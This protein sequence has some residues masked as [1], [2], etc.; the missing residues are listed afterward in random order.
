MQTRP[1]A[2]QSSSRVSS[3]QADAHEQLK[4]VVRQHL[5]TPWQAPLARHTVEAFDA[6]RELLVWSESRPIVLDSGCGTGR[7]TLELGRMY[8]DC[9]VI[10]VDR[11]A[12]RL[13]SGTGRTRWPY[14]EGNC[15]WLR[16]ELTSF[17]RL[18]LDEGWGLHR[19]YLLYPN[20]WP[21]CSQLRK[22][23][24]GHPV[25]PVILRLGGVIELR[26]NWS[27][28]A[29]EFAQAVELGTGRVVNVESFEVVEPLSP[30][31][32][33]YAASD[34]LLYRVNWDSG[35]SPQNRD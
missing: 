31:E 4:H 5:D 30:F 27:I 34:H 19:H 20:P 7:S 35:V 22:R 16:A 10:G 12:H 11:S 32:R 9:V 29:Q 13:R 15:I 18:L 3:N 6:L 24:H 1:Q 17:W 28:Y 14:R 23:W 2:S 33:K 25:F 21:K 26:T 8:P